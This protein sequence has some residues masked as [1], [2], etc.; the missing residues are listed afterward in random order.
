MS[1]YLNTMQYGGNSFGGQPVTYAGNQANQLSRTYGQQAG[2][3]TGKLAAGGMFGSSNASNDFGDLN[4]GYGQG[5]ASIDAAANQKAFQNQMAQQQMGLQANA[6]NFSQGQTNYQDQ[7]ARNAAMYNSGVNTPSNQFNNANYRQ[8][9]PQLPQ[10][11]SYQY[12]P[13]SNQFGGGF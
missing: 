4:Y 8:Q 6:Q 1:S 7:L 3:L 2:A 13:I 12:K 9:M 11:Q 10:Y 5:L